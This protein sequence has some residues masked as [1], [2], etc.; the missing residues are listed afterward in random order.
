MK[1]VKT[2]RQDC[3]T[4]S[5][6]QFGNRSFRIAYQIEDFRRVFH[7]DYVFDTLAAAEEYILSH[8]TQ[9]EFCARILGKKIAC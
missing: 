9:D 4:Y 3:H 1:T 7:V 8:E 6:N 5:I 2:I